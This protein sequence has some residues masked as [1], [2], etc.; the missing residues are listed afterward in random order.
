MFPKLYNDLGRVK[1]IEEAHAL[2][3]EDAAKAK[4]HEML[5]LGFRAHMTQ[6]ATDTGNDAVITRDWDE[7]R[8]AA[9]VILVPQTVGG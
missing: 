8:T 2:A 3:L 5:A 6:S 1:N 4:F 7:A 9:A